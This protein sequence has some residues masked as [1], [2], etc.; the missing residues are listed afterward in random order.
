MHLAYVSKVDQTSQP[1][2]LYV[3]KAYK[4]PVP[5][6]VAL[7]GIGGDE[8]ASF[9]P[10]GTRNK[11]EADKY[12]WIIATPKGREPTSLF[13]GAAEQDVLDVIAETRKQYRIDERRIYLMG[14]SMGGFGT[15]SIAQNHPD[16]FA[17]LAPMAGG[18]NP[19]RMEAIK[20]IPQIVIHG[21]NDKTILVT[22]SRA[23]VEAAQ[24]LGTEVQYIEVPGGTHENDLGPNL[25]Q[26]FE[27]FASHPKKP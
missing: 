12:G 26:I 10:L 11:D 20:S 18:G 22:Q 4:E 7:H 8:N 13:R 6:V 21:D 3:P 27:F 15:W 25:P 5:L 1:Y 9:G 23:M 24:K 16:L 17:A 2:R 14:H 19:A